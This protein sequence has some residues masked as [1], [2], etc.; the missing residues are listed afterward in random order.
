MDATRLAQIL[1]EELERDHWGTI[2]PHLF[3]MVG[4]TLEVDDTELDDND[5]EAEALQQ[6]LER[7]VQRIADEP[8][9]HFL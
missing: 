5:E 8:T 6:V 9:V 7:T 3:K 2:D 4:R 1:S